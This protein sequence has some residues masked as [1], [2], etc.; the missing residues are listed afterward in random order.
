MENIGFRLVALLIIL[1]WVGTVIYMIN[2]SRKSQKISMSEDSKSEETLRYIMNRASLTLNP[3]ALMQLFDELLIFRS[4][5]QL[6]QEN[7]MRYWKIKY[8]L[9]G[10][11]AGL[12]KRT[13]ELE[14]LEK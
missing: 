14:K 3:D 1:A 12:L 11:Y 4:T 7:R 10:K 6:S 2:H 8:Y 5:S 9:I 13:H